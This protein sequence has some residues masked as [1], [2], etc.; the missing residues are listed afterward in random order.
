MAASKK[1]P[2]RRAKTR[3]R[4]EQRAKTEQT[5]LSA[6][7]KLFA[8]RGYDRATIRA[9]ARRA[10]VDPS[11]VI[12]YFKSKDDLFARVAVQRWPLAE[13]LSAKG[14]MRDSPSD[15]SERLV[16]V[17][18]SAFL[19][20]GGD[21]EELAS[22]AA[23]LRSCM[24]NPQAARAAREILFEQAAGRDLASVLPASDATLRA[25]VGAAILMGVTIAR[26]LLKVE[27][28]ASTA[29]ADLRALLRPVLL[30][31]FSPF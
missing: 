18:L 20:S 25:E 26:S 7:R 17:L 9:I 15:A 5:I 14:P 21:A 12:Q 3:S 19:K 11:L 6:A 8:D 27:P 4:A 13:L 23:M 2:A 24:T 31:L 10:R 30:T 1:Q 22:V 29:E 28:L 16:D